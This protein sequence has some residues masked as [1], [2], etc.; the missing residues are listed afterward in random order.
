MSSSSERPL[1]VIVGCPRSGTSLFA[2]LLVHSGLRTVSQD[3]ANPE[4]PAGYYEHRPLRM[5][6]KAI[7]RLPR[8]ADHRITAEPFLRST[9]LADPFIRQIF[10]AAW[11]PM[12]SR[13]VDLIK[14]PQLALSIDFVLEQ[15]DSAHILALWR[16]PAPTFRSLVTKEFPC[17]MRPASGLKAIMLWN[18][19]A[20]HVVQAVKAHPTS[21]TVLCIDDLVDQDTSI[22]PMLRRLG[23]ATAGESRL[24]E[25]INPGVWTRRVSLPWK[26]YFE[27]MR[28]ATLSIRRF[29]SAEKASMADLAGWHRR[30]RAVTR[31]L[32]A[33]SVI[34]ARS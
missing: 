2:R 6:H 8:G 18:M 16:H 21:V 3:N 12:L 19:Y 26:L 14:F 13:G 5:F 32:E 22:S 25:C 29:L 30:I 11:E 4:Y 28:L 27:A 31:D 34:E 7:E 10:H 23:Y 15:F 33:F 17:E 20:F 9:Y 1:L 24:S